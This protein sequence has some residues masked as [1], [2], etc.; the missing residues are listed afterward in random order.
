MANCTQSGVIDY[1]SYQRTVQRCDDGCIIYGAVEGQDYEPA[2]VENEPRLGWNSGA[3]SIVTR[4]GNCYVEFDMPAVTGVVCGLANAFT[5]TD[6]SNVAAG[7]FIESAGGV[8]RYTAV[9]Y[10]VPIPGVGP[11]VHSPTALFRIERVNGTVT[12]IVDGT[13]VHVSLTKL[14]GPLIVVGLMYAAPDGIGRAA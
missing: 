4:Y 9:E 13:P 6:P 12:Y 14:Y 3:R 8:S 5:S 1:G 2:K 10:G 11:S 7:F